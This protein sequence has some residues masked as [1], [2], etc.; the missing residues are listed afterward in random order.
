MSKAKLTKAK[1][2]IYSVNKEW[3]HKRDLT[4]EKH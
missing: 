2:L 1:G 4:L 3:K